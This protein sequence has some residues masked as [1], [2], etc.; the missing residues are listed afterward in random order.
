MFEKA[1]YNQKSHV[2]RI[3]DLQ[4]KLVRCALTGWGHLCPFEGCDRGQDFPSHLQVSAEEDHKE[5]KVTCLS[6]L[7][8]PLA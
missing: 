7:S 3:L 4:P 5:L 6:R 1:G 2:I 8:K